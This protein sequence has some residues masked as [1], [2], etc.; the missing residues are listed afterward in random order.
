MHWR[1]SAGRLTW[2]KSQEALRYDLVLVLYCH[3]QRPL[4]VPAHLG[5]LFDLEWCLPHAIN[6]AGAASSAKLGDRAIG[7]L[8]RPAQPV[9]LS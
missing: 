6:L 5:S 7:N 4:D 3:S 1:P 9:R 2:C 8:L